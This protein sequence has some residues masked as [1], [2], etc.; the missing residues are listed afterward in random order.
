MWTM[1][2]PSSVETKS[3]WRIVKEGEVVVFLLTLKYGKKFNCDNPKIRNS[4]ML[5]QPHTFHFTKNSLIK[6]IENNG[7]SV[8]QC[9]NFRPASPIEGVLNKSYKKIKNRMNKIYTKV[10]MKLFHSK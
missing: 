1:P 8:L 7:Y 9:D 5:T 3:P 10:N 2:V 4:T 6:L